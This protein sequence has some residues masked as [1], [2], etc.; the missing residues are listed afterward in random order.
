MDVDVGSK[1][2]VDVGSK[3]EVVDVGSKGEIKARPLVKKKS[4]RLRLKPK[5]NIQL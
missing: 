2:E 4:F 1:S 5:V 3:S